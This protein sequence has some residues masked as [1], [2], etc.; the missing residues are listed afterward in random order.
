MPDGMRGGLRVVSV[1]ARKHAVFRYKALDACP[2]LDVS[3]E[4]L[5]VVHHSESRDGDVPAG[6]LVERVLAEGLD[7]PP[8]T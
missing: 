6:C 4:K 7:T 3:W 5:G 1:H 8:V 2:P